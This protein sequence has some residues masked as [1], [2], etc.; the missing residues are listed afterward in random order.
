M[1]REKRLSADRKR[2]NGNMRLR[3]TDGEE[4]ESYVRYEE[5]RR[6]QVEVSDV[7]WRLN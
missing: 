4:R 1:E 6:T 5:K 3:S 7:A 2:M